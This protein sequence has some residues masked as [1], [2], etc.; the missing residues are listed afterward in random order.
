MT[1][2]SVLSLA[3]NLLLAILASG[4]ALHA[5]DLPVLRHTRSS[6]LTAGV[7]DIAPGRQGEPKVR[8]TPR[9]YC[10]AWFD[11]R[12]GGM[13]MAARFARD[14]TLV[15]PL[16]VPV[17]PVTNVS[18]PPVWAVD[19]IANDDR[20]V[21]LHPAEGGIFGRVLALD[22]AEEPF[23]V[24]LVAT[25]GAVEVGAVESDR[26]V[27]V[28]HVA[29]GVV[30]TLV[31]AA[32]SILWS[33]AI[34]EQHYVTRVALSGTTAWVFVQKPGAGRLVLWRVDAAGTERFETNLPTSSSIHWG[35]V[36]D[37]EA[38]VLVDLDR[39]D[40]STAVRFDW[41]GP[42]GQ[43][44]HSR[45]VPG[46]PDVWSL[47]QLWQEDGTVYALMRS[48]SGAHLLAARPEDAVLTPLPGVWNA[49]LSGWADRFSLWHGTDERLVYAPGLPGESEGTAVTSALRAEAVADAA[50]ID[51]GLAVLWVDVP[52]TDAAETL[53][54]GIVDPGNLGLVSERVVDEGQIFGGV[55]GQA[56][57]PPRAAIEPLGDTLVIAWIEGTELNVRRA[58][59][60]GEW[61][62][63]AVVVDG[64]AETLHPNGLLPFG[65]NLLLVWAETIDPGRLARAR[66]AVVGR[67]G[68]IVPMDPPDLGRADRT[69]WIAGAPVDDGVAFVVRH[70]EPVHCVITCGPMYE[71]S[72]LLVSH[73]GVW[74]ELTHDDQYLSVLGLPTVI[75]Q[76]DRLTLLDEN[77][78]PTMLRIDGASLHRVATTRLWSAVNGLLWSGRI[79]ALSY[80][81]SSGASR[82]LL[83]S[84]LRDGFAELEVTIPDAGVSPTFLPKLV[85]SG[86]RLYV[87][88]SE[89]SLLPDEG[90]VRRVR[91]HEIVPE[92]VR[93][94]NV[95]R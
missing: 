14:R 54:L 85:A 1:M 76:G 65:E 18:S 62:G 24:P 45:V 34:E 71:V 46:L 95:R 9:G 50:A 55:P 44:L 79:H 21:V 77:L 70:R 41:L 22:G 3:A 7:P 33:H 39:P 87:V 74:S 86:E 53:R 25:T 17:S 13:V 51:G 88:S 38:L 84:R 92:V 59:P 49:A 36:S 40:N 72:F 89:V 42:E 11:T 63:E 61:L 20:C 93:R 56:P 75:G 58:T 67:D 35:V 32:G 66:V 69:G 4:S 8:A 2:R 68:S 47:R 16:G 30:V 57:V 94:R 5:L 60:A 10:A 73:D 52:S 37:G 15:D 90:G 6:R 12:Q 23:T 64:L 26:A 91:V 83:L 28:D 81:W 43:L 78:W 31:D 82:S 48:S 19:V 80:T 29:T 27:V